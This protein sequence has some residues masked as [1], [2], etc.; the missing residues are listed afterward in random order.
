MNKE[1]NELLMEVMSDDEVRTDFSCINGAKRIFDTLKAS[2]N[3]DDMED[4]DEYDN[5]SEDKDDNT[6]IPNYLRCSHSPNDNE[7]YN[8]NFWLN[9]ERFDLKYNIISDEWLSSNEE[10]IGNEDE[11]L[12]IIEKYAIP[13]RDEMVVKNFLDCVDDCR[14]VA[15][16]VYSL[17]GTFRE[18]YGDIDKVVHHK[19]AEMLLAMERSSYSHND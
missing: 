6:H 13:K 15:N 10:N 5:N 8:I 9:G 18:V 16:S 11:M 7:T 14:K 17:L 12:D 1:T 19:F 4:D 3:N 2:N